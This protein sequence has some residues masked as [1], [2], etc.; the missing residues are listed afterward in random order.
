VNP[1]PTVE[2]SAGQDPAVEVKIADHPNPWAILN[3]GV[4]TVITLATG[5]LGVTVTF[6]REFVGEVGRGW[7]GAGWIALVLSVVFNIYT[8]GRIQI[9]VRQP[10]DAAKYGDSRSLAFFNISFVFLVLGIVLIGIGAWL[11]WVSVPPEQ[12]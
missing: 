4:K 6:S 11:G 3:E 5:L 12:P 1:S 8:I 2:P 9:R 10:A 7:V